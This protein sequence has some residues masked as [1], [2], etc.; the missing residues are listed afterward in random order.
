MD[1][2]ETQLDRVK[3]ALM[4]KIPFLA[5]LLRE[6]RIVKT[7]GISSPAATSP[8]SWIYV[9]PKKM[10]DMVFE[11]I[12][13]CLAHEVLHCANLHARRG[14]GKEDHL[15][16][17]FAI[18]MVVNHLLSSLMAPPPWVITPRTVANTVDGNLEEL[19]KMS[20]LEVYDLLLEKYDYETIDLDVDDDELQRQPADRL[21]DVVLKNPMYGG[22]EGESKE[23]DI[24]GKESG[25]EE[26]DEKSVQ[27]DLMDE[28]PED[29]E[30]VQ[31]GGDF[32]DKETE[33]KKQQWERNITK[34]A[35]QQKMAGKMPAGLRRYVDGLLKPDLDV[36]SLIKQQIQNGLGNLVI[37]DWRRQSRK[38]PNLPGNKMLTTPTIWALTDTSG[39]ITKEELRL[40]LGAIY[41]FASMADISIV[42]WDADVY[43]IIKAN[44]KGQ[45]ISRVANSLKGGGGTVLKPPLE[46]VFSEMDARDIVCCLTDGGIFDLDEM[47]TQKL[48]RKVNS[49]ASTSFFC[50]T[51]QEEIEA[52]GWKVLKIQPR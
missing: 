34:A 19:E 52:N 46:K 21:P 32:N 39:S 18:D 36:R 26:S 16:W 33:E 5:S 13:F 20:D 41:E 7:E 49:K 9:N 8:N 25:D 42:P 48:L 47:E 50:T 51:G 15:K 2:L 22:G 23:G 4:S 28:E 40:F 43:K 45:V 12:A 11:E 6:A 27:G 17:N 30:T 37:D 38:H 14:L 44:S 3:T 31:K 35:T 29:S 10:K 1:N 24:T